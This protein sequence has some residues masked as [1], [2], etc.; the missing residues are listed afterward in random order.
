MSA[1]PCADGGVGRQRR[2]HRR[3]S[4][5]PGRSGRAGSRR[6][7]A[8]CAPRPDGAVAV[9]VGDAVRRVQGRDPLLVEAADGVDEGLGEDQ[10]RRHP[11]RRIVGRRPPA[12]R[13][14]AATRPRDVAP[15]RPPP[16]PPRGSPRPT[17]RSTVTARRRRLLA[18]R[19][20]DDRAG[21]DAELLASSAAHESYC[22]LGGA[23]SPVC[24]W[25]RMTSAWG[26]RRGVHRQARGPRSRGLRRGRPRDSA[27][28]R[29]PR[30]GSPRT[31]PR[32]GVARPAATTRTPP[33]PGRQLLE[34]LAAEAREPDG[35]GPGP[36]RDDVDVD[37]R[38]RR[39][40]RRPPD[41]PRARRRRPSPRRIS[42]RLQRSA[43]R[44]SSAAS[45]SSSAQVRARGRALGQQ[46]VGEQPPAL[47]APEPV[48]GP[49]RDLDAR[50]PEQ[51]DRDAHRAHRRTS[52]GCGGRSR[53]GRRI[54]IRYSP[55]ETW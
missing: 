43:R 37:D 10:A 46:Q 2:G 40:W 49:A 21:R 34:Q 3:A 33:H 44:G 53:Q 18:Q 24:R 25:S 30:A 32:A 5:P 20:L 8:R 9:L 52:A 36:V 1:W 4:A 19:R 13:R 48:G 35:L 45:K 6:S 39:Q 38:C 15:P 27:A 55:S 50:T 26:S 23:R 14:C 7:P 41:H 29:R 11:Q 28:E 47:L 51:V 22:S 54:R 17:R 31:P 16:N 12:G 42:A